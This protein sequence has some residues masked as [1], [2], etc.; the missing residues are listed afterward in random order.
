MQLHNFTP[1]GT[2]GLSGEPNG[3]GCIVH[4]VS[5]AKTFHYPLLGTT[6]GSSASCT[7]FFRSD[8]I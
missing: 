4:W 8:E 1:Q 5:G 7:I 3:I 2:A 6:F